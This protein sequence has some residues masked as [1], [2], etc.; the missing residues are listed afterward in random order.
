MRGTPSR[1]GNRGTV[2]AFPNSPASNIPR[3]TLETHST[4]SEAGGSTM[5]VS[6]QKHT[7][8][9]HTTSRARQTRKAPPGT[10]LALRPSQA[11]QI[12]PNTTVAEAAQLMAAKREDCVLV[13]DDDDRIAG[14]F[15]AKDLAF[16]VVGAGV[17]ASN[18]TIAE[19]MTKNPLCART[20]TSATDALDLM[21]RKGFRHLPVMDE[22]QDISGIL[23][24]TKC[25]YD[26]MEKL[27]RAY[28]SSRKLYDA[29][30]G[31][32]SE[33]GSSQPQQIIQYVEALR[34]KMSG[35]TL[36]SVLDGKPP[37]TVSVRTSVKD[38]AALMKENHTTAVLVQDQGSI[39]GIF[40]SKDVALR[41]IAP[42]LDP[43]TCS[44]VRVMT[45]H[46]DFAPMDM[47]IQAA[48][49]KMHDGHYLNL[50][51]MN[52]A[53]EIVGMVD[54]LKLTYATLEQ[55]NTMST[56]DSEGPAW[57]K[58]WL[59]LENETES[60]MSGEGSQHQSHQHTHGARSLMSPPHSV[61]TPGETHLEDVPFPF[62]FKA[63]SGRVP[64]LQ[65][66]ATNGLAEL[67][68]AVISKLGSEIEAVG[69]V[70]TFENGK[71]GAS[72][73]ALSYLDDDGDT[74]SITTDHDLFEAIL[75]ARQGHRDKVD[76]FVHDPE[77]A[78]ISATLDPHPV[79]P[80]EPTPPQSTIRERRKVISDE[81]ES[82]DEQPVRRRKNAPQQPMQEQVISGVPN[83]LLLPGAIVTLA[84]VIV[85]VFTLTRLTSR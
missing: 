64:K 46:P 1:G 8:K 75:I 49:R 82:E 80:N 74:V 42:G 30:E 31:V 50:P 38:A 37:T 41:V 59:S 29:L 79:I 70:A 68:E 14:I 57:N 16:R 45:P 61:V 3:P 28:S 5:S 73:F 51:V 26:A 65:V 83:E 33:L 78:P 62:K 56:G 25:F 55:I 63:P 23:D 53:G 40:T 9:K 7:K 21:V 24:I 32:Q 27:E 34:S 54:V 36:E 72:G 47:S 19:I 43:A 84:V 60:I 22:N 69:G 58:F 67:I 6:R 66:I 39:T 10:V 77:K 18:V 52:D 17:K 13:T 4:Q 85:G 15:T 2:P 44:V 71:L 35:P 11:L 20:D 48:L 81:E 12:K 76:L